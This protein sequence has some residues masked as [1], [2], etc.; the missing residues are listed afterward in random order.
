[1]EKDFFYGV[2]LKGGLVRL[3]E[4]AFTWSTMVNT[5]SRVEKS[6]RKALMRP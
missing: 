4:S 6:T 1:M 5:S 3:S 2:L